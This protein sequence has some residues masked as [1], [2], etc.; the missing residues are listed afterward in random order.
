[1]LGAAGRG[2]RNFS[3]RTG[4]DIPERSHKPRISRLD[5]RR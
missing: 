3:E 4:R 5:K 1:M 2:D